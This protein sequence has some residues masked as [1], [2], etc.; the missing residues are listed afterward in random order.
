MTAKRSLRRPRV[1]PGSEHNALFRVTMSTTGN[2]GRLTVS[3]ELDLA[4]APRFAEAIDWLTN[5]GRRRISADLS[6]VIFCD[7]AGLDAVWAARRDLAATGGELVLTRLSDALLQLIEL[8]GLRDDLGLRYPLATSA[9]RGSARW[10]LRP[11]PYH[12]T[13]AS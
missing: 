2:R 7:C 5:T 13:R 1:R 4:T 10:P 6:G 9:D 8:T 12:A 11:S 3:G